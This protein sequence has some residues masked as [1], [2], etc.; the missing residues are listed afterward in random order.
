[1][2]N[3]IYFIANWKMYGSTSLLKSLDKV[4]NLSKSKK[5]KMAKII[6]FPLLH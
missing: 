3:N 6:Y 4:I 1:M 2:T 5:Y